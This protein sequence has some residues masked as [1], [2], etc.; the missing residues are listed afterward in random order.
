MFS[1]AFDGMIKGMQEILAYV[2]GDEGAAGRI[3][4]VD[5]ANINSENTSEN[6]GMTTEKLQ[7]MAPDSQP[8]QWF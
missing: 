7:K 8:P 2:E 1:R 6:N 4:R 5:T 3:V